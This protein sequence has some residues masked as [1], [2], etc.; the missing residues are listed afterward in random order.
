MDFTF[1]KATAD[2]K[3]RIN[4]LFIEMLRAIHPADEA[5]GYEDGYLDRF[6]T[7]G[8]DWVCV[9]EK[10]GRVA[11]FLS[12]EVHREPEYPDYVYL[13]DFSV[14]AEC[15][16]QGAGTEL[17]KIAE[18]YAYDAG[19]TAI[20]LPVERSNDGAHRLYTRMGYEDDEMQGDRIRMIKKLG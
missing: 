8:E 9:A 3:G 6:F 12:I 20:L 16:G 5:G 17:Q 7:G 4:E 10:D 15:R 2:D 1:R 18:R 13:D 14:T 19:V 11:A